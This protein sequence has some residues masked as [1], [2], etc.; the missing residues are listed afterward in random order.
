ADQ[1]I[2]LI[3]PNLSG[4]GFLLKVGSISVVFLSLNQICAGILQ[5]LGRMKIPIAAAVFGCIGKVIANYFLIAIPSINIVG[6]VLGTIVCYAIASPVNMYFTYKIT[7]A[8]PDFKGIILKPLIC[9]VIMAMVCY[10]SYY[11]VYMLLPINALALIIAIL[12]GIAFYFLSMTLAGGI[13]RGDYMS[14]P[15]GGKILRVLE[16]LGIHVK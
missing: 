2:A 7:G 14:I 16:I 15:M 13:N 12:I 3:F 5:G 11:A 6:A 8:K 4:N 9:S 10:V 1:I